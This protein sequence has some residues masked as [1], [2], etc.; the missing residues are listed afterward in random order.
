MK[1]YKKESLIEALKK[2]KKLGWIKTRRPG[3]DGGVG[4]TLEDLLDIPENNLAIANTVDWELKA[5]RRDT[6]SLV[7]LFHLDPQPRKPL[8]IV[9][10][11]LLP[12]Y[13][14]PHKEAGKKYPQSEMSFRATLTGDRSTDR[15]FSIYVNSIKGQVELVFNFEKTDDRHKEWLGGVRKKLGVGTVTPIAYWTFEELQKKCAGKIKNAI[16][17]I[18]D[19]RKVN[20]HEEF[21]YSEIWKLEDFT[22]NNFLKGII[23]GK[24]FIDFDARTGHNHGTKFRMYAKDWPVFFSKVTKIP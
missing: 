2:I 12:T 20:K 22:F 24:L 4:N 5:Q 14:W 15:G 11:H 10:R 7:T 23:N 19:T 16:F 3:N 18:A 6:T 17:V 8:T 21:S 1:I 9:A 13:G